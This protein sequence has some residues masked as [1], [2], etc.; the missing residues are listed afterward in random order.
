VHIVQGGAAKRGKRMKQVLVLGATGNIGQGATAALL[1]TSPEHRGP[2][3]DWDANALGRTF[4]DNLF[5]HFIAAK[6]FIPR[7]TDGGVYIGI[8]GGMA[9]ILMRGHGYNSMYQSA[10]RTMFRYIDLKFKERDIAIRELVSSAVIS[11]ES[12]P[13]PGNTPFPWIADTQV[14]AHLRRMIEDPASFPGPIQPLNSPQGVGKSLGIDFL[15]PTIST[16]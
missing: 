3:L 9:D 5:T 10:L 15:P 11:T 7:I 8:G 13:N 6:T 16:Q 2:I 4:D 1:A 12:R 14:G